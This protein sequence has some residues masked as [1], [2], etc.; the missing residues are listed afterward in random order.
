MTEASASSRPIHRFAPH[1]VRLAALWVLAGGAT[2]AATGMPTDLPYFFGV[3]EF[4]PVFVL[5]AGAAVEVAVAVFALAQPRAGRAPLAALLAGFLALLVH[6]MLHTDA[7]CGCFG[8][9]HIPASAML[10][11]DAAFLGLVAW[12]FRAA[13]L[14]STLT[15]L[16]ASILVALVAGGSA[17]AIASSRLERTVASESPAAVAPTRPSVAF[18]PTDLAQPPTPPAAWAM[19][20]EIPEQVILRPLQWIGKPLAE[21]PLG[22]WVDTAPFP[23]KARMV[24]FYKS[25]NHCAALLKELAEKQ[26]ADPATAPTYVLVQLPTP[27]AY[28]GKLFVET[29]P[30][31]ALWVELPSVIKAY[32]MTPPWIV[33]IDGGKVV[34]AE[35]I[36]W[37]GEKA[38]GK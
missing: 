15:R 36:P 26:S 34:R 27:A 3:H 17:A 25:C 35:R 9:A 7:T 29:V 32:V 12:T 18:P 16:L 21:T 5:T 1:A 8:G 6:H 28:K 37:P 30:K 14:R 38:A 13:P 20:K 23:A 33:D 22:T 4:D 10:G 24:F 11:A 2:K 31:H 19:P